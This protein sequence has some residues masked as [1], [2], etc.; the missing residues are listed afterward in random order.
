MRLLCSHCMM[1][2]EVKQ[3]D[4]PVTCTCGHVIKSSSSL[5]PNI[6]PDIPLVKP[7]TAGWLQEM[8]WS[9]TR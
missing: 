8:F 3:E 6:S 2:H 4:L 1:E 7:L 5:P 9:E